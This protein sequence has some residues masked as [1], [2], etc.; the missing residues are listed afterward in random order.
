MLMG[1]WKL[2]A[3]KGSGR[4]R[5]KP[6]EFH[7]TSTA[8]S[9]VCVCVCVCA[10]NLKRERERERVCERER[11]GG[12]MTRFIQRSTRFLLIRDPPPPKICMQL[13]IHV[14]ASSLSLAV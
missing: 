9:C 10:A 1:D 6:K 5:R 14:F 2:D 8:R 4:D 12:E 11:E 3:R 7:S 13:H